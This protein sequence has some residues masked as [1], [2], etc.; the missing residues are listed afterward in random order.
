LHANGDM[1]IRGSK[2]VDKEAAGF[3]SYHCNATNEFGSDSQMAIV[4]R[5]NVR[6]IEWA[7]FLTDSTEG[8]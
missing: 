3:I 8:F 5:A 2:I 1:L 6:S 7:E 4:V